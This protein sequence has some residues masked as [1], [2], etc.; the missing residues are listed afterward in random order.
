MNHRHHQVV[1]GQAFARYPRCAV[2]L[3]CYC[4]S[5]DDC[6]PEYAC[7][8]AASFPEFKICVPDPKQ[9]AGARAPRR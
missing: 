5:D 6:A 9:A 8:P 3:E 1:S 4:A 2:A 7:L